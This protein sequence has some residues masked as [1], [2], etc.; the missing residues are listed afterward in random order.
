MPS[1]GKGFLGAALTVT[2][3]SLGLIKT[4]E[5]IPEVHYVNANDEL[6]SYWPS[7]EMGEG[8]PECEFLNNSIIYKSDLCSHFVLSRPSSSPAQAFDRA[9]RCAA[10]F[11]SEC[12]LSPEVGLAIPAAFV[13]NGT[14][15]RMLIGPR[16]FTLESEQRSIR[17]SQPGNSL[18]TRTV[19][20]NVSLDVEY[21]D[22][23][24]RSLLRAVLHPPESYCVQL[25]RRAFVPECWQSLD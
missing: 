18:S 16:L 9:R 4:D 14:D 3:T 2:L 21:L 5:P 15:L 24:T 6:L 11:E 12:V 23:T 19:R 1:I 13:A 22:G 20:F 8:R 10:A 7:E 17:I 25:L